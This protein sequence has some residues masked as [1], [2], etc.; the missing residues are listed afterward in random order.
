MAK[1]FLEVIAVETSAL[2]RA[3]GC[4]TAAGMFFQPGAEDI[5]QAI[6][7]GLR[8]EEEPEEIYKICVERVTADKSV[9]AMAS[10]IIFF[11]VR[12]NLPMKKACMAA[13]KT[14]DK[15]KDS[16]IKSLADALIAADTPKRRGQLVANFLESKDLRDKLGLSIYLNVMEMED[17]FHAHL[18]QIEKL[19]EIE[20]RIMAS[21]FSGAIY[22]LKEVSAEIKEKH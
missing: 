17:T 7:L 10:L 11:L 13:W 18:I 4:M 1:C 20:T 22:G 19:P 14:A 3:R 9:L 5:S 15:F 2:E 16:I 12:D 21:A 8:T 6:E